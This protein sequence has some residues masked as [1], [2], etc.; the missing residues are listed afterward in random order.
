M[1][2]RWRF[3]GGV[4]LIWLLATIVDRLWWTL[5]VGVPALDQADYFNSH[6]RPWSCAWTASS[7]CVARVECVLDLSPTI[8]PLESLVNVSVMAVSGG[9]PDQAEWSFSLWHGLLLMAFAG[10]VHRLCGPG[11]AWLACDVSQRCE[12]RLMESMGG[13]SVS[14]RAV[15]STQNPCFG[16]PAI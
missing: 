9:V 4:A 13:M 14:D 15:S 8:P 1:S 11:F 5:Q 7:R 2:Q 12:P 10:W 3:W 6:P 16:H